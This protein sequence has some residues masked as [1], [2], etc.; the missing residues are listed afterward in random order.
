VAARCIAAINSTSGANTRT[1]GRASRAR[2]SKFDGNW[3]AQATG[4]VRPTLNAGG[5][6]TSD[7][8]GCPTM[9]RSPQGSGG[10]ATPS[11]GRHMRDLQR[12][13]PLCGYN[14]LIL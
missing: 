1:N 11:C 12:A 14:M 6:P 2:R 5:T 13:K 10:C 3:L 7:I 4:R 8:G 9:T